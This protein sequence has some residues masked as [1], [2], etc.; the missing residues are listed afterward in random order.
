MTTWQWADDRESMAALAASIITREVNGGVL[1]LPTGATPVPVYRRLQ[2][3]YE[4][5]EVSFRDV[6]TFNLDEYVGVPE[7]AQQSYHRY[8]EEHF[9]GVVDVDRRRVHVPH[10]MARD[11]EKSCREY[12]ASIESAGGIGLA[13]L[14]LGQNGH[15]GFNE[16]GEDW[17]QKTHVVSLSESTRRANRQYFPKH[18]EVPKRAITVGIQTIVA[19]RAILLLVSGAEKT[20]ALLRL[21]RGIPSR[22]WP[23]TSLAGHGRLDV[24]V[25]RSSV[26][27]DVY[28]DIV[29]RIPATL[30]R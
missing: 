25:D 3:L 9:F 7:E 24:V 17:E 10:G 12:D 27:E 21:S 8:M 1:L 5:G 6:T 13:V 29:S 14:G 11:L 22:E 19:S 28:R 18:A 4:R 16:P 15:V 26:S 2:E 30:E 20:E 23:V